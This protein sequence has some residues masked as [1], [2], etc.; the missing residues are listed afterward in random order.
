MI[1]LTQT[2]AK[3][4]KFIIQIHSPARA[5]TYAIIN[6]SVLQNIFPG[7]CKIPGDFPDFFPGVVDTLH[8]ILHCHCAGNQLQPT[9]IRFSLLS[10][11]N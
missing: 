4:K 11:N 8:S 9:S 7:I 2:S 6:I 3:L 1:L 10:S 5:A